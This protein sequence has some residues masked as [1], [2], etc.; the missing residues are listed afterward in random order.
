MSEGYTSGGY[1]CVVKKLL[2]ALENSCA[3]VVRGMP[4][5]SLPH[6]TLLPF[7]HPPAPLLPFARSALSRLRP[8]RSHFDSVIT[9]YAEME[10][11]PTPLF[12]G[13]LSSLNAAIERHPDFE[14]PKPTIEWK[15]PHLI[16]YL[17]T[18]LVS[19]H[20]DS[21]RYSGGAVAVLT[22]EGERTVTLR[23]APDEEV[24]WGLTPFGFGGGRRRPGDG[25]TRLWRSMGTSW[26]SRWA[27]GTA[28]F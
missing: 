23:R 11:P 20:V 15:A 13:L 3:W 26:S 2:F 18:G 27:R 25:G 10:A 22:L 19:P 14:L 5:P 21:V 24:D 12:K 16:R 17:P 9:N 1:G 7:R 6:L 8:S 28:T 4:A